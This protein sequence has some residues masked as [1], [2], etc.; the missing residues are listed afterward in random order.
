MK[1]ARARGRKGGRFSDKLTEAL[2]GSAR[3]RGRK[4]GRPRADR[5]KVDTA[6]K[7]YESGS[8]SIG[9]ICAST[10]ISKST[11]YRYLH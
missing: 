3:A 1:A 10:G 8:F 6:R 11:L 5:S 7:M 4:G 2:T 9:E